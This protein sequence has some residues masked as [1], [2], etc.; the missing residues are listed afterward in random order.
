MLRSGID[1]EK[2]ALGLGLVA[3]LA[4]RVLQPRLV[5]TDTPHQPPDHL[6]LG[7]GIRQLLLTDFDHAMI[8]A[9]GAVSASLG[10]E[11]DM[12]PG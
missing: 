9:S 1:E 6:S 4:E 5:C 2:L 11:Q 10:N 7:T 3:I 8:V 12:E